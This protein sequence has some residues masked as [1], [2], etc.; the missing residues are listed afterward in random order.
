MAEEGGA[1]PAL[2]ALAAAAAEEK[3]VLVMSRMGVGPG[4]AGGSSLTG[5]GG[6]VTGAGVGVT[7]LR[8]RPE[9]SG[10]ARRE[11]EEG[12]EGASLGSAYAW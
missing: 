12:V 9:E 4:A 3:P 2:S 6:L 1:A 11:A 8:L 5:V 10:A 7:R